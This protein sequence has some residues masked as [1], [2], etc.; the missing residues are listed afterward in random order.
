[1]EPRPSSKSNLYERLA[2][3]A[4]RAAERRRELAVLV[5]RTV[6]LRRFEQVLAALAPRGA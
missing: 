5:R 3:S 2:Q 1:M 4:Q 6:N